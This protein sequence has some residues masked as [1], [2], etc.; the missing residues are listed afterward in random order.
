MGRLLNFNRQIGQVLVTYVTHYWVMAGIAAGLVFAAA[1]QLVINPS[2]AKLP[3]GL[4]LVLSFAIALP[5]FFLS[6]LLVPQAKAQFAH[7]R[8]RLVPGYAGPHVAVLSGL[9]LLLM[10]L[11]PLVI[12]RTFQ[13]DRVGLMALTTAIVAPTI[14]AA[15][16]SRM[17][18]ILVPL[19]VLYSTF[20]EAG[21]NWWLLQTESHRPLLTLIVLAG[22]AMSGFWLSRLC[23]LREEMDDYQNAVQWRASRRPGSETSEQRRILAEQIRRSKLTAWIYDQWFARIDRHH[24]DHLFR[25]ARLLRFGFGLPSELQGLLMGALFAAFTL[26]MAKFNFLSGGPTSRNLGAIQFYM[27]FGV[28]LPGFMAGEQLAQRRPRIAGELLRPLSRY[29]LVDGLLAA[30]I[31]HWAGFWAV[32]NVGLLLVSWQTLGNQFTWKVVV[33][34]LLV[35]ATASFGLCTLCIRTAV[36]PSKV[37]RIVALMISAGVFQIPVIFWTA[38]RTTMGDLPAVFVAALMVVI[39]GLLIHNARN[40]WLKTELG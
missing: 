9:L 32:M 14:L 17:A 6:I 20:T 22:L 18:M 31:W 40:A 21:A 26:F 19:A 7:V 27:Q 5:A 16:F 39:G 30:T 23:R 8:A 25:I 37:K 1:P 10:V 4:M 11:Y 24:N 12:A 15:H 35:S 13:L 33:V 36:W 28:L 2:S 34:M 3:G 38:G 29:Q